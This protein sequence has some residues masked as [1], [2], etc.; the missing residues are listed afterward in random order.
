MNSDDG[1]DGDVC[2]RG[3]AAGSAPDGGLKRG[4]A[5]PHSLSTLQVC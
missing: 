1:G 5:S 4:V 2:V 3:G